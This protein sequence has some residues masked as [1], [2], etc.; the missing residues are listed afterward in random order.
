MN[1][2]CIQARRAAR[3]LTQLYGEHLAPSGL[4]PAQFGLLSLLDTRS[5]LS[6]AEIAAALD[7]DQ[8]TLSRNLALLVTTR[9]I[10][11]AR[12]RDDKRMA[13]YVLTATGVQKHRV[14]LSGWL[15]AQQTMQQRLGSDWET[16]QALLERLASAAVQ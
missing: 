4:T 2:L 12:G 15:K 14:A 11:R 8:T 1:C 10:K 6:Q 16:A 9:A 7:L 13:T 5:H 3:S